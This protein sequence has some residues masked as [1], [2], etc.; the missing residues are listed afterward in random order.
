MRPFGFVLVGTLLLGSTWS[1]AETGAAGWLRYAPIEDASVKAQYSKLPGSVVSLDDSVLTRSAQSEMVRGIEGMLDR[2]L[3][4]ES[5]LPADGA[6]VLG[7]VTEVETRFPN[8]R[9]VVPLKAEAYATGMV[10]EHGHTYWL[11]AGADPRGILYG[12]FR[13]LEQMGEQH[14]LAAL[15][16]TESPSAPVRWVDQWDN[17]NGTIERGYAGRSIFFDNGSVRSDMTRPGEYARLLASVGINGCA[18]NNVNADLKMLTPEMIAQVAR[19]A[20]AFR[21]WGVRLS[22][23]VDLSSPKVVGGLDT[24]DPLDSRVIAWWQKAVDQ[25]YAQ[26]PDFAGF[27][28]KADSEGRA[29]PSQYGRT[30]VDAANVLARALEAAW[31]SAALSSIRL[32]PSSRL[33]RSE[34]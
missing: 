10:Q 34:G 32:Q 31:R 22:M 15:A 20:D 2:K 12:T 21:P 23:S 30:P 9:P 17:L 4:V 33:E 1:V 8:W 24:F 3:R 29:G 14:S 16:L 26:I 25:V 27:V 7:T 5:T 11:I 6:F 13:L 28:V 19:I 18:I